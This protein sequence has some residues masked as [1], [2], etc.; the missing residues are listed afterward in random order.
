VHVLA[1]TVIV[2][3][4]CDIAVTLGALYLLPVLTG[5]I[6]RGPGIGPVAVINVLLGWTLVG[7]AVALALVL[8]SAR[9]HGPAVP[10]AQHLP[11]SVAVPPQAGG[12]GIRPGLRPRREGV[13]PPLE[14]PPRRPAARVPRAGHA[15]LHADG[16]RAGR[17]LPASPGA[18]AP[19][20]PRRQ[21]DHRHLH[22]PVGIT[23]RRAP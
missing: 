18:A 6:R 4:R 10:T 1:S 15:H 9:E 8:R 14:L 22:P 16:R 7:W 20:L 5:W 3:L 23:A 13:P 21:N 2:I 12:R 17:A 11:D 19:A